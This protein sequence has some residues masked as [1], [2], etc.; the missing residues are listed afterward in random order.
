MMLARDEKIIDYPQ[1]REPVVLYM[2]LEVDY[3][4]LYLTDST[5]WFEFTH[6]TY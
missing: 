6:T 1:V 2:S 4:E 5:Q 3:F